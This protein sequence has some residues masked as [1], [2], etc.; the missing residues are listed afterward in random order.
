MLAG[1]FEVDENELAEFCRHNGIRKLALF[2]SVLTGRF[3]DA[4]DVDVLVEFEPGRR[5][6]YLR[7]AALERE[8]S[9]LL[10]G[11]KIDL[12]T[13]SEL[14]RYF[15]DEILRSAAIQYVSQ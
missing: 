13:P 14:S 7:M 5:V 2:G 4:S 11:R 3:T 15:R 12:R 9:A 10:R 1:R 6:G 8:L